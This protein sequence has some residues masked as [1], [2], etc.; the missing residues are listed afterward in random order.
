M[1]GQGRGRGGGVA[2]KTKGFMSEGYLSSHGGL[3]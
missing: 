2:R 3:V 1:W